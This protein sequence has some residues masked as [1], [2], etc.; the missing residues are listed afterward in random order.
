MTLEV[1]LPEPEFHHTFNLRLCAISPDATQHQW[2]CEHRGVGPVFYDRD[3]ASLW[4][5][6]LLGLE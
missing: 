2:Q 4:M 1:T 3:E 5:T 6:I